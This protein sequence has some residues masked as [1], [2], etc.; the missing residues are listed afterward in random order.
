MTVAEPSLSLRAAEF[1][2]RLQS[3][4]V[5]GDGAMGTMLN[6]RGVSFDNCFEG[7]NLSSPQLV[8]DIHRT[9][10]RAGADIIETNTFGANR[11]RLQAFG[12]AEQLIAINRA[13][14]RLAREA[15]AEEQF[16]AGA[17]GPVGGPRDHIRAVF[18]EQAS[19]LAQAGA[20]LLILE[21]FYDLD[22]L[23]EAVQAVRQAVGSEVPI[24]AHVTVNADGRMNDG[25]SV[26]DFTRALDALPVDVI[27]VNCSTGPDV[28]LKTVERMAHFSPKPLSA[29]PNAGLPA[30]AGE[31][32]AYSCSPRHLAQYVRRFVGAGVRL[33]GGCCGTTPEHIQ[34]I[35][36]EIQSL[37]A[38]SSLNQN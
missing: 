15:A 9:Y 30:T 6:A 8:A 2:A 38:P 17:L 28:L 1:R 11:V 5:V 24:A 19:A 27:G 14:V 21:T 13:G 35:R 31:S 4:I 10:A 7:L 36:S 25:A 3:Q 34:L 18:Q 16:V 32:P 29:M 12:L 37:Q 33:I 26:A 22:E 23:V 20:D